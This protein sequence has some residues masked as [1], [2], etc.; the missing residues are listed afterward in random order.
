MS[1][2]GV[3]V[4]LILL[5]IQCNIT[6]QRDCKTK[7]SKVIQSGHKKALERA[8]NSWL[9]REEFHME[10]LQLK[11]LYFFYVLTPNVLIF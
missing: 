2:I 3:V 8:T 9:S 5:L 11:H 6:S 1:D 10:T 4:P 7:F